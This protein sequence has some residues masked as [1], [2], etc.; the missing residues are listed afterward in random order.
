LGW[1]TGGQ[2]E[3]TALKNSKMVVIFAL[4]LLPIIKPVLRNLRFTEMLVIYLQLDVS[5]LVQHLVK[6]RHC[7]PEL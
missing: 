2:L 5:L 1:G 7:L 6:I 3:R 4:A